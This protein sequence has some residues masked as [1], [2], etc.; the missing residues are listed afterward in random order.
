MENIEKKIE[1]QLN[2]IYDFFK[3]NNINKYSNYSRK[4]L[5]NIKKLDLSSSKLSYIPKEIYIY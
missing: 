4:K 3:K 5:L 2:N 1:A